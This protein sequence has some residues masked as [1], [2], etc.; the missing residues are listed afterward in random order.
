MYVGERCSMVTLDAVRASAGIR[1]IAVAPLPITTIFLPEWS[2]VSGQN[3]GCT[4]SP[5]KSSMPG[6]SGVYASS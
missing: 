5:V 6:N 4:T 2:S 3:C 1:L